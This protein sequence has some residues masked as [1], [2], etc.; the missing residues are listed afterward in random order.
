MAITGRRVT[1]TD[2]PTLLSTRP[3]DKGHP[4]SALLVRV[5]ADGVGP[6][7][8]GDDTVTT[9][10]GYEL[11]PGDPPLAWVLDWNESV[12]AVAADGQ[13]VVVHV[14]EEGV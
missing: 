10:E 1:V 6:V 14:A 7:D 12:Y 4:G 8:V 3:T 13:S 2:A 5:P 9:G 11:A